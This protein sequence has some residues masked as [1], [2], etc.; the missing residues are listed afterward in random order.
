MLATTRIS[1][2]RSLRT[3]RRYWGRLEILSADFVHIDISAR[4]SPATRAQSAA[5]PHFDPGCSPGHSHKSAYFDTSICNILA[6][7]RVKLCGNIYQYSDNR[8]GRRSKT[9][10]ARSGLNRFRTR[11]SVFLGDEE[12][13]ALALGGAGLHLAEL[14]V[15]AALSQQRFMFASLDDLPP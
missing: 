14:G 3:R 15:E 9:G 11:A 6:V 1:S 8:F 10:S 4:E 7:W 13:L 2:L 12:E 5:D